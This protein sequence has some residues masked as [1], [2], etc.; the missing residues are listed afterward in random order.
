M[1]EGMY[2]RVRACVIASVCMYVSM[3][4]SMSV[5]FCLCVCVCMNACFVDAS[6]RIFVQYDFSESNE[7]MKYCVLYVKAGK[8]VFIFR[9]F[10][11]AIM[12]KSKCDIEKRERQK[13]MKK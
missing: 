2:G 13:Q 7:N 8:C 9:V 11:N 3:Y 6:E 4:F 12:N 10:K 5:W 1:Y